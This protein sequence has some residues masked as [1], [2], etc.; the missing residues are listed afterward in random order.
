MKVSIGQAA[1]EPGVSRETLRRWEASDRIEVE[2]TSKGH[3]RDDLSR[4]Q[5]MTPRPPLSG[6][7]TSAIACISS[8]KR[9]LCCGSLKAE[10][11]LGQSQYVCEVCGLI[12]DRDSIGVLNLEELLV[13]ADGDD[14]TNETTASS[15]GSRTCGEDASPGFQAILAEAG[16]EPH[17]T[18]CR[19]VQVSENGTRHSIPF[20]HRGTSSQKTMSHNR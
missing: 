15:A 19:S 8:A 5:G 20:L 17:S 1:Q 14:R 6:R 4:Q 9:C 12:I 13:R 7:P 11:D 10:M 3:R 18:E 2:R 16:T